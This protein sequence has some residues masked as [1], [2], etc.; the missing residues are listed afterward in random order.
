M[1]HLFQVPPV[2]VLPGELLDVR[3]LV[4]RPIVEV[5]LMGGGVQR[6]W[7]LKCT[8]THVLRMCTCSTLEVAAT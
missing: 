4:D 1:I 6:L 8:T 5:F 2:K 3:V 7:Q